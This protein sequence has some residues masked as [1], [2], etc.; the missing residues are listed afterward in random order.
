MSRIVIFGGSGYLGARLCKY[1]DDNAYPLLPTGHSRSELLQKHLKTT[2]HKVDALDYRQVSGVISADDII[3]NLISTNENVAARKP[4]FALRQTVESG[5]NIL[6][7]S[8]EAKIG[9][10]IYISTYHVYD[11]NQRILNEESAV[12]P[13]NHY[14]W[15]H[16][17]LEEYAKYYSS[18]CQ[19]PVDIVRLSNVY[20]APLFPEVDRWTLLVNDL[21]RQAAQSKSL[22]LKSD[23]SHQRD[24]LSMGNFLT[25]IEYLI[26]HNDSQS[27]TVYNLGS[28]ETHSV[29]ET[30]DFII[31]RSKVVLG[32]DLAVYWGKEKSSQKNMPLDIHKICLLGWRPHKFPDVKEIDETLKICLLQPSDHSQNA[33]TGF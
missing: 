2:V 18:R 22:R 1:L 11:Q 33:P 27:C 31:E 32:I 7:A 5:L 9:K 24:F 29:R 14:G 12:N 15:I 25:G 26:K 28:G 8:K 4:S 23:G 10:L 21:C 30:V 3:I 19:F 17:I 16:K 6:E 13:A 20:G